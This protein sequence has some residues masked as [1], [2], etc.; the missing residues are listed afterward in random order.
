MSIWCLCEIV[1]SLVGC[2]GMTVRD[3]LAV[4][5]TKYPAMCRGDVDRVKNSGDRFILFWDTS[6]G[7]YLIDIVEARYVDTCIGDGFKRGSQSSRL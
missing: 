7:S 6:L 3:I 1:S 2:G 5:G 4:A